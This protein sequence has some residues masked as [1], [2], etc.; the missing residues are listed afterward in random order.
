MSY[1]HQAGRYAFDSL[2]VEEGDIETVERLN[3]EKYPHKD[4]SNC[5]MFANLHRNLC[6]YGSL[7]GNTHIEGGYSIQHPFCSMHEKKYAKYRSKES[8]D[9]VGSLYY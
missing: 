1:K 6:E 2:I 4:A 5:R 7:Q 8:E 3:R 9:H